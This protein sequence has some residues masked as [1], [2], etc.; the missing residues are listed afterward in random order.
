[1]PSGHLSRQAATSFAAMVAFV[2]SLSFF[3]Y[4]KVTSSKVGTPHCKC[5]RGVPQRKPKAPGVKSARRE[6]AT[7]TK[8]S[9]TLSFTKSDPSKPCRKV[10]GLLALPAV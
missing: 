3:R 5:P 4:T 8:K 9:L 6:K 10:P 1:V 2:A 7:P